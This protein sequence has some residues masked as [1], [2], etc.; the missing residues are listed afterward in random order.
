MGW[1]DGNPANL[2]PLSPKDEATEFVHCMGGSDAVI[3]EAQSY[4]NDKNYR[5]AATLLNK[6]IFA[7]ANSQPAKDALAT[8]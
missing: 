8:V 1:F 4:V 6:V 7:D 5:F 2:W 3:E